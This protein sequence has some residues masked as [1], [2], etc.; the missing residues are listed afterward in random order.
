MT[1]IE[2][3]VAKV[4]AG[5]LAGAVTVILVWVAGLAGVEIPPEVASAITT[6]L[7]FIAGYFA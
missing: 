2:K 7:S 1:E 5:A 4:T 6:V 3:P